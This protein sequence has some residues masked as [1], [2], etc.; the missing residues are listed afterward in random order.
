MITPRQMHSYDRKTN[1]TWN[2]QEYKTPKIYQDPK[3]QIQQR[4][5]DV[6][7]K[8]KKTDKYVTKR[9]FY[10]DYDLKVSKSLPASC[11]FF[12]YFSKTWKTRSMDFPKG[13]ETS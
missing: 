8:G 6:Q 10:M 9:G 4:I 11:M 7:E 13:L 5:W 3:L 12:L 1:E 2:K